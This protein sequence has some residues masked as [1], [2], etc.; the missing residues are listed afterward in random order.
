MILSNAWALFSKLTLDISLHCYGTK[1][2]TQTTSSKPP[3]YEWFIDKCKKS[4]R[5]FY[6]T[7]RTFLADKTDENKILFLDPRTSYVQGNRQAK[8]S[9]N[10]NEKVKLSSMSKTSPRKFW[11]YLKT[12]RHANNISNDLILYECVKHV[13]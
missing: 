10:Y 4:K 9:Y 6:E 12:F 7:K 8:S 1:Y 2:K 11:K 13:S 5:K 3:K